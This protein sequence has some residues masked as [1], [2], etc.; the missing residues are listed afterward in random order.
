MTVNP[1]IGALIF[2]A[3]AQES[4]MSDA[5]RKRVSPDDA[6]WGAAAARAFLRDFKALPMDR[7]EAPEAFK[8]AQA[9]LAQLEADAAGIPS[10]QVR[11]VPYTL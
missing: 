2:P 8:Q 9:L 3:M 6:Q 1:N 4:G 5:K 11:P 7:M 10:L